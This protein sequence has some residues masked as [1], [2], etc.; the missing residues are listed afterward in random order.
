[1]CINFL[2]REHT[3]EPGTGE[4]VGSPASLVGEEM[5]ANKVTAERLSSA[6]VMD[7][8]WRRASFGRVVREVLWKK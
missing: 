4:I 6:S 2:N 8:S 1:M 5:K 3:Q 7:S